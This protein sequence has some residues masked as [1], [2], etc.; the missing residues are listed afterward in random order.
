MDVESMLLMLLK[1]RIKAR[2][3]SRGGSSRQRCSSDT[4]RSFNTEQFAKNKGDMN[5]N[6]YAEMKKAFKIN[7]L[8]QNSLNESVVPMRRT[9]LTL[10]QFRGDDKLQCHVDGPAL[11]PVVPE[12]KLKPKE[13]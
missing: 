11:Q 7:G 9:P 13:C 6:T 12:I 3:F 4:P 5:F 8:I 10:R 1:Q 2:H